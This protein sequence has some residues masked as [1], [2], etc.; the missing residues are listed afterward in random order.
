MSESLDYDVL[1]IGGG[2]AGATAALLLARAGARVVVLEKAV[3]P[4]FRIGESL[5]PRAFP[6][7][8]E[9]GLEQ[10]VRNVPSVPKLGVEFAMGDG[11]PVAF[12]FSQGLIPGSPTLSV[13][14]AAFDQV[15][16]DHAR[17]AGATVRDGVGLKNI[18]KLAD[19]DVRIVADDGQELHG[20][21]L[22]DC[23]GQN[24][25][26]G[27]HLATRKTSSDRLF[28]RIAY[29]SHFQFVRRQPG[30][31]AGY[32]FVVMC[33]EA[34][35]WIIPI[36]EARTSIGM[37]M[38]AQLAKQAGMPA[39]QM[40]AW[41]IA[42]CPAVR[43][44]MENAVG[45]D[46]NQIISNFSYSCRPYAG[47][48]YFLVGDS[49]TFLDPIFSSGVTL[50][51]LAAQQA[52]LHVQ[53]LLANRRSPAAARRQY[54]RFVERG[55]GIFFKLARQYYGHSFR[56]LFLN[57]AGPLQVHSAV[58][59]VLAGQ[60][61]PRIPWSLRWRLWLFGM[62]GQL[63]KVTPLVPRRKRFSLFAQSVPSA[64]QKEDHHGD[65]EARRGG[66]S[67]IRSSKSETIS[68]LKGR[69]LKTRTAGRTL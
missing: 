32:P 38:D 13:E 27:R 11:E 17:A 4:R 2:P 42:R 69:N 60:V 25:V 52:A 51:M 6:L 36:D 21:W 3:F 66:K 24:T 40:L 53:A 47:P 5:L 49:A 59:S 65:T 44:R 9:L 64:S 28:Q 55:S 14:R 63:N 37:V 10:A 50:A 35:F 57:G 15:L 48:G 56:E 26:V 39:N 29:F 43:E 34:W 23:S 22:L 58:L 16:L 41:G 19:G 8:Q 46:T 30:E 62:L 61:F 54:I 18:L 67:E 68:K 31:L 33:E 20:R 12:G 45:P 7:I 1:I